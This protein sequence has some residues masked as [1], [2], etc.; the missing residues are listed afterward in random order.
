MGAAL[1]PLNQEWSSDL[2][3]FNGATRLRRRIVQLA[4]SSACGFHNR[5]FDSGKELNSKTHTRQKKKEENSSIVINSPRMQKQ[6]PQAVYGY[7]FGPP[8]YQ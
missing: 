6:Y 1:Y 5:T 4:L 8:G 2:I 7:A 3:L